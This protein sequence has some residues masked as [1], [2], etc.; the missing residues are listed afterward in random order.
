M[1]LQISVFLVVLG[2]LVILSD[3][4]LH[5][6]TSNP[7]TSPL[8]NGHFRKSFEA[9]VKIVGYGWWLTVKCC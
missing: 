8:I 4:E 6:M 2:Q 7:S 5:F 1:Y 9:L 3:R